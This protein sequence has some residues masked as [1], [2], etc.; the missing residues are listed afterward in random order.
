MKNLSSLFRGIVA[1]ALLTMVFVGTDIIGVRAAVEYEPTIRMGDNSPMTRDEFLDWGSRK[2]VRL[3]NI[4]DRVYPR[5]IFFRGNNGKAFSYG[6]LDGQILYV[7]HIPGLTS[8][9]RVIH[10]QETPCVPVQKYQSK[11]AAHPI[12]F[13]DRSALH[14]SNE[15]LTAIMEAAPRGPMYTKSGMTLP[16]RRLTESELEAW[17]DEYNQMGGASAFEIAVVMEINRVR[18]EYGLRPLAFDPALMMSARLKTQEFG[19]LQYFSHYSP[20][21][22][23]VTEAANMFGFTGLAGETIS[24]TG[25]NSRTP[26]FHENPKRVVGGMLASTKGH[27][28]ILLSPT[29]YS[30]GFGIFFSPNSTGAS[31]NMSYMFYVATKFGF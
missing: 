18:V 29:A 13:I 26:H 9:P 24:R 17:I 1:V 12:T 11:N 14:L 21:H 3:V 6:I 7:V 2:G 5:C 10:H 30:V 22:G 23:T 4:E 19:D 15:E 27:R 20:V 16:N 31:G 25:S 28:E 8:I